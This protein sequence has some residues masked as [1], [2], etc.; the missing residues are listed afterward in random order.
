MHKFTLPQE[1]ISLIQSVRDGGGRALLVGGAVRDQLRCQPVTQD[2]DIEVYGLKAQPLK[3]ILRSAGKVL[4]VGKTFGI[5]NLQ[6][7][8]GV[9]DFCLPRLC[10]LYTSDAADE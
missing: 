4:E 6:T 8:S 9:Y 3:T 5:F 1:L 10:L 2:F 7:A